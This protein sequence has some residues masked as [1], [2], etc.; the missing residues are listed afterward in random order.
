MSKGF[1]QG[2]TIVLD[3]HHVLT[4][5]VAPPE[6]GDEFWCRYCGTDRRVEDAP[7][8]YRAICQS[9]R[10]TLSRNTGAARDK[11]IAIAQNHVTKMTRHKVKV[12]NGRRTIAEI[13]NTDTALFVTADERSAIVAE[14]QKLLRDFGLGTTNAA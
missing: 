14:G 5:I 1:H 2:A 4:G 13:T 3:C 11:A 7:P 12:I 9:G 10:C 6:I 8:V